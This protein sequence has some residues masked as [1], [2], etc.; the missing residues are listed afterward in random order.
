MSKK[1]QLRGG[2]TSEH[3]SFTGAVREVTVDTDKD[4][5]VV[6]D[7]TTAGGFTIPRT[8]ADIED[9][10]IAATSV[11]GAQ[12]SAIS[13]NTAKTGITSGQASAI[14][15]NTAKVTNATH[16]GDVTGST[17]L[18]IA[19]DAVDI[20]MLSATGTAGSTT[21]LRG[22]NTWATA[23]ST[24]ASDLTSGTL[25]DGRFPATLPAISGANLTNL[26]IPAAVA[27]GTADFVASGTL[28]NGAPVVLKSDGTVEVVGLVET[29]VDENTTVENEVDF[30]SAQVD[31]PAIA[32]DPYNA[33]K[34]LVAYGKNSATQ[35]VIGTIS[36]TNIT[37]GTPT[38]IG[39]VHSH[40]N[41]IA[42][43]P[44]SSGKFVVAFRSN[45]AGGPGAALAGTVSGTTITAGSSATFD[46]NSVRDV[47]VTFDPNTA[48][49]FVVA[50]QDE[51][52]G[53]AGE[54]R[55]GTVT[56]T[57]ITYGAVATFS[58]S[59]MSIDIAYY[60]NTA[61]KFLIAYRDKSNSHHGTAQI[62][63]VSGTSITFGAKYVFNSGQSSYNQ[64]AFVP[65]T[66]DKFLITYDY[67]TGYALIGTVS[68]TSLTYGSTAIY[69]TS[70]H[71]FPSLSL[72]TISGNKFAIAYRD[73]SNSSYGTVVSGAI[74][75]NSVSFG[76]PTVFAAAAST[77]TKMSF[78]PNNAGK[79]VAVYKDTDDSDHGTAVLGQISSTALLPNLTATNFLGTST[80]A[81]TNAQT[82]TIMLQGGV[83]A[84]QTGLTV[85]STYYVQTGG[86]LST[87]AGSPSVE[88]GKALSA[89]SL[90][91]SDTADPAVALNTAKT[92]ITSDQA[93]A[94]TANTAKVTNST[95][96]SDLSSGTLADARFP[97]TLPALSGANL[98]DLP[99]SA[100]GLAGFEAS[101]T[102]PNGAPVV[103]K[104]DG[105]V[106]VVRAPAYSA[107][108]IPAG[109]PVSF[110]TG[111][112]EFADV[113]IDPYDPN[114]FIIAYP[115][116]NKGYVVV[117]TVSGTSITFGTPAE[118]HPTF[119]GGNSYL[120]MAF[121]PSTPGKFVIIHKDYLISYRHS[122]IVGTVSGTS[123]SFGTS[124]QCGSD[125]IY[126]VS[127]AFDPNT[128]GKFLVS[129]RSNGGKVIIGTV[130][131]TSVS[132]GT[133]YVF[134]TSAVSDT[135]IAFDPNAVDKFIIVFED[136]N[137]G[138]ARVGTISGT[139]ISYGTL[140][141]FNSSDC[142]AISLAVDSNN[143]GK[144]VITYRDSGNLN[145][146]TA[147]AGEWSGTSIT[148]GAKYVFN[149]GEIDQSYSSLAFDPNTPGTFAVVYKD[150]S[151]SGYGTLSLGSVSGTSITFDTKRVFNSATTYGLSL[152]YDSSN[153][154]KFLIAYS[155][156][157]GAWAVVG[158]FEAAAVPTNLTATNFL[159]TST[160]SYNKDQ[161]ATIM[162]QGGVSTNQ[163]GLTIG[164]T[165]YVQPD[166]TLATTAGTPSVEAGKALS[167]TSLFLSD[168]PIIT[169][170]A[171]FVASGTL[172]N[173]KPV[174][175]KA[176]GTVEVVELASN[177]VPESIPAGTVVAM[178]SGTNP[179][180][181]GIAFDPNTAG[182]FVMAYK[183]AGNS[184]KGTA[185]V[186][187]V[188]GTSITF[189]T[190][191]IFN[192]EW[193]YNV[194]MAFDPNEAG[195][196]VAVYRDYGN[197]N[198]GNAIVGTVSGTTISFGSEYTFAS[199]SISIPNIDFDP[200]TTGKFVITYKMGSSP[201]S[202]KAIVGT[203][204]GNSLSFGTTA[205]FNAGEAYTMFVSFDPNTAG[206]FV[207]IYMDRSN[208]DN[209]TAIVGTMSGT[210]ASFGT[211]VVFSTGTGSIMSID[212]TPN[213]AGKFVIAYRDAADTNN[214]KARV[215][216]VSGT[217]VS[218]GTEVVFSTGNAS[219]LHVAFDQGT[220]DKFV[221]FY[222]D[223]DNSNYGEVIVG[224]ISGTSVSFGT[225][226]VINTVYSM[227]PHVA[228][229]P[230][231]SGKF[232]M[233]YVNYNTS[234]YVGAGEA[235]VGQ[236][237]VTSVSP[238]LTAT[239]FLGTSQAAYTDTQTASIMLQ[240]SISTNQTGLTIGSTYY[241]QPDGTLA[242]TAGTP[243][244]IAGKAISATSLLLKGI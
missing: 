205:V 15:A 87:T 153:N 162:L 224:T 11:T 105:T 80:D 71:A 211:P 149:S 85:G 64:I 223:G 237:S 53:D 92:G 21:F 51:T 241:V 137:K 61:D 9:L 225:A 73:Q 70:T 81:Y 191:V 13:A 182:T 194:T 144:F 107:E 14:T 104:S 100:A 66:V 233:A 220:E 217:S 197:S 22:D 180:D 39:S 124:V 24:S 2:T 89:T 109:S 60:P 33:N 175:L 170:T 26:P 158:Q 114:K 200:N 65:N 1:L 30:L 228:F 150:I 91:L 126:G 4:T 219:E 231:G 49:R 111:L 178:P 192:S 122:A 3:S 69:T 218:F 195:K 48:G 56:G 63:T 58:T 17:V 128:A 125:I 156:G 161:T 235:V 139:S 79:F 83:S 222:N 133:E 5:L 113:V 172:P 44:S 16:T 132:F 131:G 7:G 93:S 138:K 151:N 19:T 75:G 110:R 184:D 167:A 154:G 146:G 106:E 189:G 168:K 27:S 183:D 243:S 127:I 59:A 23:G 212:F 86:T 90:F 102:L 96:A 108:S 209:G 62:G 34:F 196:F 136:G 12:A 215:G 187:V 186:G 152:A 120:T 99:I 176:D 77:N 98:T 201:Y 32:F 36:G 74:S 76:T 123:I 169:G 28:P 230:N 20:P 179:I 88:A 171:D 101:G 112:Y 190:P 204:S 159:G 41:S 202:G 31:Y 199:S 72:D 232:V 147:V 221:V 10:G 216:T 193:S 140:V 25:P 141:E 238:N 134:D 8:K 173:G 129:Y 46:T 55:L 57:S 244:V 208:A 226:V 6:H 117:G 188:S 198:Y 116:S 229:D 174:V 38:P 240:G 130:S 227:R 135:N 42:F 213:T 50:Y 29:P 18:T 115:Y 239:N 210:S 185:I 45:V 94:I 160:A 166:G 43:D 242:T 142:T 145:Y 67:Y 181:M 214:G 177:T 40:Y 54:I 103:L 35:I 82:A 206:K 155:D 119:Y 207:V 148:F 203:R 95:S 165:Y 52:N 236:I 97:A 234:T 37:F 143:L 68:G 121:D 157:G 164:S 163:T 78:D 47:I 84:N 118:F